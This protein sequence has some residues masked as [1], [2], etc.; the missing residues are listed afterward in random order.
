[1][2]EQK[3]GWQAIQGFF[4]GLAGVTN[5]VGGIVDTGANMA[6]DFARGKGA[7]ADQQ[8]DKAEREQDMFLARLKVDRGDNVQL[9][10]AGAFVAVLAVVLLAK[11]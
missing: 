9:Y 11:G 7:I 6:E 8:L 5:T 2:A 10:W 4:N 3:T 1:M